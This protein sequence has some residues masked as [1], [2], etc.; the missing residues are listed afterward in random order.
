MEFDTIPDQCRDISSVRE[1][2]RMQ[3]AHVLSLLKPIWPV[4]GIHNTYEISDEANETIGSS[5]HVA[6]KWTPAGRHVLVL[7]GRQC[8]GLTV[9]LGSTS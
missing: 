9:G 2:S 6:R 4:Q 3:C 1:D 5:V 7:R 8:L